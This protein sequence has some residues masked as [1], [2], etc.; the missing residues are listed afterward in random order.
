MAFTNR[1]PTRYYRSFNIVSRNYCEKSI[2]QREEEG[3]PPRTVHGK[4]YPDWRKPWIQREGEWKSKLSV[5]VERNPSG[6]MMNALSQ[7]PDLSFE[8]VKTWWKSMKE[9]QEIHNQKFIAE[10]VATLGSNLAAMHFLTYRQA[11]V[12]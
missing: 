9:L 10:R 3:T 8:K 7:I 12:R 5:F 2:Y 6:D 11:A 4:L 1:L